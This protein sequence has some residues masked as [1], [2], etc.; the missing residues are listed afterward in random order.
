M[1]KW[2][3]NSVPLLNFVTKS[4]ILPW[5]NYSICF[6]ILQKLFFCMHI[7][8][9]AY[10]WFFIIIFMTYSRTE[11]LLSF[12]SDT[13]WGTILFGSIGPVLFP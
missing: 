11:S 8:I 5:I 12:K 10:Y 6:L 7:T 4:I 13:L 9:P 1:T 3:S 2:D